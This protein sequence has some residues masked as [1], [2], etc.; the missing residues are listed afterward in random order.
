VSGPGAPSAATKKR[1]IYAQEQ[2]A[3]ERAAWRREIEPLD[4]WQYVFVDEAS[5]TV[6]MARR[7]ARAPGKHRAYGYVPRNYGTRTTLI[8]SLTPSGMGPAMTLPG[9]ADTEAIVAYVEQV[10]CPALRPG[11]I[12]F[13]DNVNTHKDPRVRA[14]IEAQGCSLW[15]LPRYS[16]D[17]TPIELAF[18]KIKTLL[19]TAMARTPEALEAAIAEAL[20]AITASDAQGWF[21][22]CGHELSCAT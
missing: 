20:E 7:Y 19:R 4:A 22:H 3:E 9:A 14:L 21:K 13:L 12:V 18:A 16:P 11:Q 6:N 17:C 1:T 5:T 15:W 8:A 10:L 2:D